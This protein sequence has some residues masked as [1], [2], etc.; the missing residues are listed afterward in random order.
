MIPRLK[1][2]ERLLCWLLFRIEAKNGFGVGGFTKLDMEAM[3]WFVND[4]H[5]IHCTVCSLMRDYVYIRMAREYEKER[6]N[7]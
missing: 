2:Y 6:R 5:V 4:D 3:R 7:A 1:W